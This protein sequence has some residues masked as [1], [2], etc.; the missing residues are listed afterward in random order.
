MFFLLS[1]QFSQRKIFADLFYQFL[2]VTLGVGIGFVL[3]GSFPIGVGKDRFKIAEIIVM[4]LP[5]ID[6]MVTESS[7]LIDVGH[8]DSLDAI[9]EHNDQLQHIRAGHAAMTGNRAHRITHYC[10]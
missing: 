4:F 10:N 5:S 7:I 2:P 8:P 1:C 3:S 6:E 9:I